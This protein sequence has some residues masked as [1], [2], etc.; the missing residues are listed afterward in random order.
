MSNTATPTDR[1]RRELDDRIGTLAAQIHAL[2]AELVTTLA[3]HDTAGGWQDNSYRSHAQW[4]SVRTK[5]T[6]ADSRR[7]AGLVARIDAV[8]TLMN[9]A[10]AGQVSIGVVATAA[11]I[12]TP[13]NEAAIAE[14]IRCC[15]PEQSRRVLSSYRDLTPQPD[16]DPEPGVEPKQDLWWRHWIDDQ[17][18]CRID[19]ALDAATGAL[20]ATARDAAQAA[21]ERTAGE[22]TT[23]ESPRRLT[24]DEV[25]AAMASTTLAATNT[26]GTRDRGG[27]R[28]AVHVTCDLATLCAAMGVQLDSTL[29]VGL[30]SRAY[31]CATGQHLSNTELSAI[32]C[33]ADLQLLIEHDGAPLWLGH[34]KRFFNR[35]QRRA[36]NHRSGG[37]GGCEFVGCT[38]TKWVETHHITQAHHITDVTTAGQPTS[39]TASCSAPSTTTNSTA[40]TG[41]SPDPAP[42]SPSGTEPHPSAPPA[43]PAPHP[44]HHHTTP[45]SH[46]SNNPPTHPHTSDP[47]PPPHTPAG[48]E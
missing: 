18:R 8:P 26:A 7:F 33:D 43:H 28:F 24:A 12:C 2:E 23:G 20:L 31:L 45:H 9:D 46:S 41:P 11:R 5:F 48:N 27:E 39:T 42:N 13:D 34:T 10:R 47:T 17:G 3:E 1:C 21:A 38:H 36:L 30:G 22:E 19:A 14:M 40:T 6:P 4:I 32:A 35:H 25:T 16:S 44:D 15:T 29:P 37:T